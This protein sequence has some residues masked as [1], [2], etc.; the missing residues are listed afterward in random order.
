[1]APGSRI[2]SVLSLEE[3]VLLAT[4]GRS[5]VEVP[6]LVAYWDFSPSAEFPRFIRFGKS[7]VA[8][9]GHANVP[10]Q[11]NAQGDNQSIA[12]TTSFDYSRL[13]FR[14]AALSAAA[15]S[16]ILVVDDSQSGSGRLGLSLKWPEGQPL[17]AGT[18][19]LLRLTF[20]R[21]GDPGSG[22]IPLDFSGSPTAQAGI[23]SRGSRIPLEFLPN[24][25]L[26]VAGLE[27][28]VSPRPSGSGGAGLTVGDWVQI[29]RFAAGLDTPAPGA[30]FQRADCA[31]AASFGDGRMTIADWVQAGRFAAGLDSVLPASGPSE[32]TP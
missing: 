15:A 19:E 7:T 26:I 10:I 11:L 18:H 1:M 20:E 2:G 12:F 5:P 4:K 16:G 9:G 22:A 21:L 13:A 8:P 25:V 17:A 23:N 14:S 3:A 6:G 29:G 28:D 30:E 32:P 31:P 27:A 24:E